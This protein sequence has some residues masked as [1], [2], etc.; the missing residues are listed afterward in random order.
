MSAGSA[1]PEACAAGVSVERR[2]LL[3]LP[4]AALGGKL[5]V[6]AP[7][8]SQE[9]AGA[10]GAF[11]PL[12]H[13]ELGR[14]WQAL[15]RELVT[16]PAQHDECYAAQ[17]AGLVARVPL[18]ALPKLEQPNRSPGIAAGPSWFLAPCVMIEFQ[19]DPGAV[20]RLHNHPPQVVLTLCAAGE[21]SYRHF[22]LE[23]EEVPCT[24]LGIDF[25]VR[26][27]RAGFLTAGRTTALTRTRDGIHGFVAGKHGARLIDFTVSTTA[28]I[29]TFSYLE[30]A[31]GPL[32]AERRVYEARWSGKT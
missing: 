18:A 26:E 11:T 25:L 16:L 5:V 3:W 6:G 22:E 15:A 30:L 27:S 13:D 31:P 2:S 12:T 10:G 4:F 28:D 17:L 1:S 14:R 29:E 24:E 21:V 20:V 23:G 19:L 9:T 32:D 7:L 8:E